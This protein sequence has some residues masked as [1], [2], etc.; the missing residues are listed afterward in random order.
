MFK[1]TGIGIYIDM[2][3][4]NE[5]YF[6]IVLRIEKMKIEELKEKLTQEYRN[7]LEQRV[8]N[9]SQPHDL[10]GC[11]LW[12]RS[13][14]GSGYPQLNIT[15]NGWGKRP[16]SVHQLVYILN[17]NDIDTTRYEISHLC[18]NKLCVNIAHLVQESPVQNSQR[19]TCHH[20]GRCFGHR[21]PDC[22][23]RRD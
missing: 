7:A 10:T 16:V 1:L 2:S 19:K 3:F 12:T 20:E 4:S 5:Y 23:F 22:I 8:S 18:G 14:G 11:I 17:N 13:T 15:V 21:G 6:F 9:Y